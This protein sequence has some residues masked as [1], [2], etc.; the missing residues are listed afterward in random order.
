MSIPSLFRCSICDST[1]RVVKVEAP[2]AFD[3]RL[4]CVSCGNPLQARENE[5]VLKYFQ[6][7]R[8][9]DRKRVNG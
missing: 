6:I 1:Y 8:G 3:G 7:E 5:Y 4:A 9:N 2:P